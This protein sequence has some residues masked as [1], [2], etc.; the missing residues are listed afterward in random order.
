[1]SVKT[2]DSS[3]RRG[4]YVVFALV[5]TVIVWSYWT[6]F[7]AVVGRWGSD[8]QYSHGY[9]V[10]LFSIGLL[11]MR[12]DLLEPS[13][14]SPS[15]WGI[16]LV[17]AGAGMRILGTLFYFDWLD[18]VSLLPI[19]GGFVLLLGG[20]NALRWSWPAIGFLFFMIPL[21]HQVETAMRGPLRQIG[22]LSGTYI[23]QTFGLPAISEGNTIIVDE[24]RIGVGEA[25]SGLR[26]LMIFFALSTAVALLTERVPWERLLIV[27]S[28]VPIALIANIARL[29]VT[30]MVHRTMGARIADVVFHDLA[31]WLMMPLALGLLWVELWVLSHLFVAEEK[32][33]V[34]VGLRVG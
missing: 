7:E 14:L 3:G 28:A 22:T 19:L 11:W 16:S 24:A 9:L 21:P 30:A 20:T 32:H 10:P 8:P 31:G 2:K 25:C 33:H 18:S 34:R 27:A 13:L 26:M 12:R 17:I 29:S 15:W 5:T 23:L 6:T 4:L 1:M